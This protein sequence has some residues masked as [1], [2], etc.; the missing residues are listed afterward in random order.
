M[1]VVVAGCDV[2]SEFIVSGFQSFMSL[3]K[4]V[5]RP[6]DQKRSGLSLGE[7]AAT[8]VLTDDENASNDAAMIE[9]T[10][11]APAAAPYT[12][13]FDAAIDLNGWAIED[14]NADANTWGLSANGVGGTGALTYGYSATVNADDWAFSTCLDLVGGTTYTVQLD[15]AVANADYAEKLD[16][17][18]GNAQASAS[19]TLIEDLGSLTN[20]EFMTGSYDFTPTT[21]GTYYVGI[22]CYSDMNMYNLYVD[23]FSI[24]FSTNVEK[25]VASAIS[26]FPNPANNIITIANAENANITIINMVGA[27]VS[28]VDNASANQTIDI[29]ELA[30]GTYFVRVNSEV[31]KI[32]VVK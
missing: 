14:A 3:S 23:N 32:N 8:V 6:F 24:D 4:G 21:D 31:F 5:C 20:I 29:S 10:N 18:Y 2:L 27:V 12:S 9:V 15:Y 13:V 22:H 11:M 19:M 1:H 26:V 25:E 7:G 17:Y 16:V 28:T 30:N